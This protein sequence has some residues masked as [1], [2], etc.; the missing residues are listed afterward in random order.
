MS[1]FTG[2][3]LPTPAE[4]F[5]DGRRFIQYGI[6]PVKMAAI[7]I[8]ERKNKRGTRSNPII[9]DGKEYIKLSDGRLVQLDH[10]DP[11]TMEKY[12]LSKD[13]VLTK[14]AIE[15]LDEFASKTIEPDEDCPE[16]TDEQI[17][18]IMRKALAQKNQK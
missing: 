8:R 1:D 2:N 17:N 6:S 15:R 3:V 4:F 11:Q 18:S 7:K 10:Y 16:L 9:K 13:S 5:L 12:S 14:D